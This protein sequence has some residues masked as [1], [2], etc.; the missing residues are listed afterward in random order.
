MAVPTSRSQS[1]FSLGN[2]GA[3]A[4]PSAG[5]KA[6]SGSRGQG[7]NP[8]LVP[9]A[10]GQHRLLPRGLG[11]PTPPSSLCSPPK[12][13]SKHSP[14]CLG[15]RNKMNLIFS[16]DR[17]CLEA[18]KGFQSSREKDGSQF[19]GLI[20][21]ICLPARQR[22]GEDLP[23]QELCSHRKHLFQTFKSHFPMSPAPFSAESSQQS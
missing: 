10:G 5:P 20:N 13:L 14:G 21:N 17:S 23:E 15:R 12:A 3:G 1:L 8:A 19:T 2:G 7:D 9:M 16:A 6:L 18:F 4:Q 22:E 11:A